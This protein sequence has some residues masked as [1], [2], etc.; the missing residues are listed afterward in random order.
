MVALGPGP[1]ALLWGYLQ[2]PNFLAIGPV[3]LLSALFLC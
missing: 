3:D 2:L 1:R